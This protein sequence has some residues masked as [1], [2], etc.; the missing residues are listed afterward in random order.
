MFQVSLG[1]YTLVHVYNAE[2]HLLYSSCQGPPRWLAPSSSSRWGEVWHFMM[3]RDNCER[4]VSFYIVFSCLYLK[5]CCLLPQTFIRPPKMV[6]FLTIVVLTGERCVLFFHMCCIWM[7]AHLSV[8]GFISRLSRDKENG[9]PDKCSWRTV[10]RY[11]AR[12]HRSSFCWK[13]SY[14]FFMWMEMHVSV[15]YLRYRI[16]EANI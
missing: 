14:P 11:G 15:F 10:D 7:V 8:H 12:R 16:I 1:C 9:V 6:T 2:E 3:G 4:L 5:L 13:V